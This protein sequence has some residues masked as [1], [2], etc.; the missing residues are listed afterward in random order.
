MRQTLVVHVSLS[1]AVRLHLTSVS[2][3]LRP[4]FLSRAEHG[5][6]KCCCITDVRSSLCTYFQRRL[7]RF[8]WF[9]CRIRVFI[10]D[11]RI[12]NVRRISPV[13]R[14]CNRRGIGDV[15]RARSVRRLIRR[16]MKGARII[17]RSEMSVRHAYR[18]K[19]TYSGRWTGDLNGAGDVGES[20]YGEKEDI[21]ER[22]GEGSIGDF[23]A[24]ILAKDPMRPQYVSKMV[25]SINCRARSRDAVG[26]SS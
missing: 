8:R 1:S 5:L 13:R 11:T 2:K 21:R 15:T 22:S 24:I 20:E 12:I 6:A 26:E 10:L 14:C 4:H 23:N 3:H 19:K 7:R 25:R 17:V 16:G 18:G 9:W